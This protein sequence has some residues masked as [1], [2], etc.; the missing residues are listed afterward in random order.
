MC[1]MFMYEMLTVI[2]K[3]LDY[4]H[5]V[6][7]TPFYPI[8]ARLVSVVIAHFTTRNMIPVRYESLKQL[9]VPYLTNSKWDSKMDGKM[10]T[11]CIPTCE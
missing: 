11:M 5:S 3:Q 7:D 10:Q 1:R 2:I 8:M 4:N 6:F 9:I